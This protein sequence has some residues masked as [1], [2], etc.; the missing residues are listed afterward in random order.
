[1]QRKG[2]ASRKE[3]DEK[4]LLNI[5]WQLQLEPDATTFLL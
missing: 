1:M 2:K 3:M 4:Y 5:V